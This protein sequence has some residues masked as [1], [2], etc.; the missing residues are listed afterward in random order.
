MSIETDSLL[1]PTDFASKPSSIAVNDLTASQGKA[2]E[3]KQISQ[4]GGKHG[5]FV[6][7]ISTAVP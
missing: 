6:Y 3:L 2:V 7:F 4:A 1:F 5:F